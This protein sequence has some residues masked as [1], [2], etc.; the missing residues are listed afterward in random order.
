MEERIA[1]IQAGRAGALGPVIRVAPSGD[2]RTL[3]GHDADLVVQQL[4]ELIAQP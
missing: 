1:R 2:G 3:L 4:T